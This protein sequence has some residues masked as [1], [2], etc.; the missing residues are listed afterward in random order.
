MIPLCCWDRCNMPGTI[1]K[2]IRISPDKLKLAAGGTLE[3][4]QTN[5]MHRTAFRWRRRPAVANHC[6]FSVILEGGES[7]SSKSIEWLIAT[8]EAS[9][10]SP[11]YRGLRL[12][13]IS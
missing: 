4:F 3:S 13:A 12:I 5:D 8:I 6:S 7:L 10:Y 9:A 1:R 2:V 11:G